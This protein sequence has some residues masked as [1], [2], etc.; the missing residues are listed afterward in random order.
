MNKIIICF[1]FVF[2]SLNAGAEAHVDKKISTLHSPDARACSFFRLEGVAQA[3]EITPNNP[4]FGLSFSHPAYDQIFSMMLAAR[5]S[6][7]TITVVTKSSVVCG[8]A[9]VSHVII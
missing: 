4:W 7:R 3:D 8:H 2:S 5:I 9:E 1:L 6:E